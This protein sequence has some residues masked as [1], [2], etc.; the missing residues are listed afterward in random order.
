MEAYAMSAFEGKRLRDDGMDSADGKRA[1]VVDGQDDSVVLKLLVPNSQT[2]SLIGKQGVVRTA[3]QSAHAPRT[4]TAPSCCSKYRIT[5]H[6]YR[7]APDV[8]SRP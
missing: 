8:P 2:G 1:R 5:L 4:S 6:L 7:A 3:H